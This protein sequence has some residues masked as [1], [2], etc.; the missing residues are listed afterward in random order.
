MKVHHRVRQKEWNLNRD[1][2]LNIKNKISVINT[3]AVVVLRYGGRCRHH[4][5]IRESGMIAEQDYEKTDDNKRC[6]T[7]KKPIRLIFD[8]SWLMQ[9]LPLITC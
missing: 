7:I 9:C 1:Q 8:N 6:T 2:S 3:R 4:R 5:E